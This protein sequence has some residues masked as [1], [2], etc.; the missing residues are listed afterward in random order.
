MLDISGS[1]AAA[2]ASE[3]TDTRDWQTLLHLYHY[4]TFAIECIHLTEVRTVRL[5]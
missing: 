2:T 3:K 5:P 4:S 1:A